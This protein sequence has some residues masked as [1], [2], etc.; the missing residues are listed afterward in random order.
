MITTKA[1]GAGLGTQHYQAQLESFA[2]PVIT[3]LRPITTPPDYFFPL[4]RV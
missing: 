1:T 4:A 3:P 2:G